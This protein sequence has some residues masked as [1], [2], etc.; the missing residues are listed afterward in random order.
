MSVWAGLAAWGHV[1]G[2][3]R[4]VRGSDIGFV[5]LRLGAGGLV[6]LLMAVARSIKNA[7]FCS[8]R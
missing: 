2:S 1:A 7:V 4:D 5:K 6:V 3:A 8:P